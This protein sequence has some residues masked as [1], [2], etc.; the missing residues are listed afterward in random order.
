MSD[1]LFWLVFVLFF[2]LIGILGVIISA[3][4]HFLQQPKRLGTSF[5]VIF[6]LLLS[7]RDRREPSHQQAAQEQKE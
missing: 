6:D 4:D 2:H 7:F 5:S 3:S 1:R